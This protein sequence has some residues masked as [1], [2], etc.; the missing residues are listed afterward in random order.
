MATN[1]RRRFS[2]S[3]RLRQI[4]KR[5][6][7]LPFF[8]SKAFPSKNE[9]KKKNHM[10]VF[11]CEH[12]LTCLGRHTRNSSNSTSVLALPLP[13]H[14]EEKNFISTEEQFGARRPPHDPAAIKRSFG[15]WKSRPCRNASRTLRK[16]PLERNPFLSL[17]FGKLTAHVR[18]NTSSD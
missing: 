4:R 9:K 10:K 18:A 11:S 1:K 3:S 16:W 17:Q 2:P 15:R 13:S 8:F 12:L 7:K 14:E 6:C 5:P